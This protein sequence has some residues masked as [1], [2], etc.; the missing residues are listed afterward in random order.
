MTDGWMDGWMDAYGLLDAEHW[1]QI[2]LFISDGLHH[3]HDL[4]LL[5]LREREYLERLL[6]REIAAGDRKVASGS[7][8]RY[9]EQLDRRA[10]RSIV[11]VRVVQ[12][13]SFERLVGIEPDAARAERSDD[14]SSSEDL[15]QQRLGAS[16]DINVRQ[17][18]LARGWRGFDIERVEEM[19]DR[20]VLDSITIGAAERCVGLVESVRSTCSRSV[21]DSIAGSLDI[22]H[23]LSISIMIYRYQS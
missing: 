7:G 3:A 12:R 18:D 19:H 21:R 2:V 10:H 14:R 11:I 20:L 4:M 15:D 5:P 6:Q 9:V 16:S 1:S 8:Q 22:N 23:D 17:G 13:D